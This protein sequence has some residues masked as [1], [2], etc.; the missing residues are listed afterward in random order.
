MSSF[1]HPAR[2]AAEPHGAGDGAWFWLLAELRAAFHRRHSPKPPSSAPARR[3]HGFKSMGL[4]RM[5]PQRN[6][7]RDGVVSPPGGC[8]SSCCFPRST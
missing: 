4:A 5:C 2:V 6:H 8:G 1:F 3:V 7:L